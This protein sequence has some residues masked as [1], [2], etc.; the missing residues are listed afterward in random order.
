MFTGQLFLILH[1]LFNHVNVRQAIAQ[2]PW[3][4]RQGSFMNQ[5]NLDPSRPNYGI[6][7]PLGKNDQTHHLWVEQLSNC[8]HLPCHSA[9]TADP[10]CD[11]A[12][13]YAS[14]GLEVEPR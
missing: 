9:D 7:E 10:S 5:P 14:E 4:D 8:M 12:E 6:H 1:T 13:W 2:T 3:V 11:L